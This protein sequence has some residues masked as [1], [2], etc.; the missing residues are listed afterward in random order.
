M[1]NWE[2]LHRRI[3]ETGIPPRRLVSKPK[4]KALDA[5]EEE[6]AVKLPK[7]YRDFIQV[8]GPG[9]IARNIRIYAPCGKQST[10]FDLYVD[11]R[12]RHESFLLRHRQNVDKRTKTLKDPELRRLARLILFGSTFLGDLFGFDPEDVTDQN[13]PEYRI[14][15]WEKLSDSAQPIAD[16][17]SDFITD[18]CLGEGY[19][20]ILTKGSIIKTRNVYEPALRD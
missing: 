2:R 3:F 18:V 15:F 9:V 16:A 8:F 1:T 12:G 10:T 13:D 6:F 11:N 5:F 7:S 14:F 19:F 4:N 17:F 20:K